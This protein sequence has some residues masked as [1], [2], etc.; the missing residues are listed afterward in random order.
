M[1][2]ET[3]SEFQVCAS[4]WLFVAQAAP[5]KNFA[6]IEQVR[7]AKSQKVQKTTFTNTSE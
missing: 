2:P 7:S 3:S 4:C 1:P 6:K 5:K